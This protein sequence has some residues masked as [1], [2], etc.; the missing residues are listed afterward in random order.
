MS[1]EDLLAEEPPVVLIRQGQPDA[2]DAGGVPTENAKD[3]NYVQ[4]RLMRLNARQVESWMAKGVRCEYEFLSLDQTLQ[5]GDR[6]RQA[7]TP[8]FPQGRT[9][10]ITGIGA[11]WEEKGTI[12]AHAKYPMEEMR[13]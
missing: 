10:R 4:G 2:T 5:N 11:I 8:A 6:I 13:R 1:L 3:V 7:P 12:P 9:F